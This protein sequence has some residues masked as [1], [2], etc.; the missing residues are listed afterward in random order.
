M[1]DNSRRAEVMAKVNTYKMQMGCC[2]C[3]VA[4]PVV[5]LFHHTGEKKK[6]FGI[7]TAVNQGK[8][9][10]YIQK[11]IEKCIVVCA[12]DHMRIHSMIRKG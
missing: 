4:D 10:E 8:S 11:E 6:E 5:L 3:G 9:W 12:N 7:A 2:M 1:R